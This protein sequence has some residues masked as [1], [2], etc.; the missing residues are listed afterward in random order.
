MDSASTRKMIHDSPS[1]PMT[2]ASKIRV[3]QCFATTI[4]PEPKLHNRGSTEALGT[5][6]RGSSRATNVRSS[7]TKQRLLVI[8]DQRRILSVMP[9][10]VAN[11]VAGYG[12]YYRRL[13]MT[14]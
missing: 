2:A 13:R 7:A 9:P 11:A 6:L 3:D 12:M 10:I 14:S 8:D 1:N 5:E 4:Y